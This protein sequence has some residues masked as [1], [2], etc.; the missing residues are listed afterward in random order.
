MARRPE[1]EGTKVAAVGV[2][3]LEDA[4]GFEALHEDLL[5][6]VVELLVGL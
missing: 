5:D 3:P 2:G 4:A 1:Q 6:R